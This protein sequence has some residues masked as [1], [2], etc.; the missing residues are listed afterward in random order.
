MSAQAIYSSSLA[1]TGERMV[2]HASD[3]ATELFHWQRYLFFR[4]WYE[5]KKVVDAASGEG[6]GT[7]YAAN[8]ALAATGVEL[9]TDA[10]THSR[11]KYPKPEFV[12]GDVCEYD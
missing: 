3:I 7:N 5:G 8:F 4:P 11:G 6:Y 2:P 12:Q 1:F 10:L 9:A